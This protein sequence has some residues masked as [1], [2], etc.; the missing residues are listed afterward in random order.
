MNAP[1]TSDIAKISIFCKQITC[2]SAV[3]SFKLQ[4]HCQGSSAG[5][6][7]MAGEAAQMLHCAQRK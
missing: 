5:T 3:S 6:V 1:V 7:R 4:E 2:L